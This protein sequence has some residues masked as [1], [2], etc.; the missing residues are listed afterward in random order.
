MTSVPS[1]LEVEVGVRSHR[2]T[3]GDLGGAVV[4]GAV[5]PHVTVAGDPSGERGGPW[6]LVGFGLHP[7]GT[8]GCELSSRVS[9]WA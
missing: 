3:T 4:I 9:A 7:T 8:E 6:L 2:S 1:H 5:Q